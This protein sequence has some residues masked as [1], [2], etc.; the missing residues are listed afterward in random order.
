M[1]LKPSNNR[2]TKNINRS[3]QTLLSVAFDINSRVHV[4][5]VFE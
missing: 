1:S 2:A 3:S 5:K 4:A